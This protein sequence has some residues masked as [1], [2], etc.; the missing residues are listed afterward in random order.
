L[1][2]KGFQ[3]AEILENVVLLVEMESVEKDRENLI[4]RNVSRNPLDRMVN[5]VRNRASRQAVIL[6]RRVRAPW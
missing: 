6:Q 2:A 4:V 3:A 5:G 1:P